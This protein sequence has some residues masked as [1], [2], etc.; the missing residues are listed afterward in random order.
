MRDDELH[1]QEGIE[2]L[3]SLLSLSG[4][5]R[6]LSHLSP[7]ISDRQ[8]YRPAQFLAASEVEFGLPPG[9]QL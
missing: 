5:L 6:G 3:P 4:G 9:A 1:A 2:G 8:Q 7:K